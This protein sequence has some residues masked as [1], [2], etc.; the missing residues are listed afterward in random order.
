MKDD[1]DIN[2]APSLGKTRGFR[3]AHISKRRVNQQHGTLFCKSQVRL[4]PGIVGCC[5]HRM[6]ASSLRSSAPKKSRQAPTHKQPRS[7]TAGR[8][9]KERATMER[10]RAS[11]RLQRSRRAEKAA[12]LSLP[13][14]TVRYSNDG[15]RMHTTRKCRTYTGPGGHHA[16][17]TRAPEK[18]S[19]A[20]R[21]APGQKVQ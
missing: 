19:A 21:T 9:V 7:S 13:L 20:Q 17:R 15:V 2:V 4:W 18:R 1:W 11:R 8:M 12:V 5:A 10:G 6:A 14:P 3:S 16:M